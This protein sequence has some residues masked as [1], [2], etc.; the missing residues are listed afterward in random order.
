MRKTNDK[1]L[2]EA[3]EQMLQVYKINGVTRKPE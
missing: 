2:K 3:I 1:F